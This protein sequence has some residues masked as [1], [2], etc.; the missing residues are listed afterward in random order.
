MMKKL[1]FFGVV[2]SLGLSSCG[3]FEFEAVPEIR[4][5]AYIQTKLAEGGDD[6]CVGWFEGVYNTT[7]QEA[8]NDAI[9]ASGKFL[10]IPW[11]FRGSKTIW[12]ESTL[13]NWTLKDMTHWGQM[14]SAGPANFPVDPTLLILEAKEYPSHLIYTYPHATGPVEHFKIE[15]KEN[16][17]D[18]WDALSFNM[19]KYSG[20][21]TV[22]QMESL[23]PDEDC[24]LYIHVKGYGMFTLGY[25]PAV[26]Y[27]GFKIKFLEATAEELAATI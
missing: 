25:F 4:D 12:V 14:A 23:Q 9:D 16:V 10:E 19:P 1:L 13:N 2:L 21:I 17:T 22:T 26:L 6:L 3:Y 24:S 11:S 27:T 8:I 18:V 20:S 7:M 15:W 5:Y